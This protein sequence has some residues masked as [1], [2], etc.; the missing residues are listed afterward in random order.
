MHNNE[1]IFSKTKNLLGHIKYRS[2][3]N[4][5]RYLAS[6]IN[7]RNKDYSKDN[8]KLNEVWKKKSL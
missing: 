7:L 4:F 3:V 1:S 5:F 8:Y 6:Q 2:K